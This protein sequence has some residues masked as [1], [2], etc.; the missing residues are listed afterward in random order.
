MDPEAQLFE[1]ETRYHFFCQGDPLDPGSE[2]GERSRG[3]SGTTT[4]TDQDVGGTEI[5]EGEGKYFSR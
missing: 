2:G 4:R 3:D 5:N 1:E